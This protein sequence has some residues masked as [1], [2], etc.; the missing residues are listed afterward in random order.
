MI[1]KEFKRLQQ[2]LSRLINLLFGL[3]SKFQ[4]WNSLLLF[5]NLAKLVCQ[6][7]SFFPRCVLFQGGRNFRNQMDQLFFCNAEEIKSGRFKMV[8][9][10][11][12]ITVITL[13]ITSI[14]ASLQ[15][16]IDHYSFS[17]AQLFLFLNKLNLLMSV[18]LIC[19]LRKDK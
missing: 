13:V 1:I 10:T 5:Y 11:Q 8:N 7:L 16:P 4:T 9:F 17:K 15:K 14:I 18:L 3:Y 2:Y 12:T 19:I 6:V